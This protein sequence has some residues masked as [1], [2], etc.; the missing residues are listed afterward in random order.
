MTK[1]ILI[2]NQSMERFPES[3]TLQLPPQKKRNLMSQFV[4]LSPES[5][6]NKKKRSGRRT[7]QYVFTEHGMSIIANISMKT[8]KQNVEIGQLEQELGYGI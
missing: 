5:V 6:S 1:D 7:L 8:G 2:D 4:T 3:L